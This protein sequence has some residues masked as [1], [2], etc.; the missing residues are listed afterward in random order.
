MP[1]KE[2]S[3]R[4]PFPVTTTLNKVEAPAWNCTIY[5][6]KFDPAQLPIHVTV[7]E[8]GWVYLMIPN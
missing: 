6:K 7:A 3:T 2:P 4:D 8:T 5:D 1:L